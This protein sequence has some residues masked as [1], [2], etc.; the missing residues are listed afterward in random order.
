GRTASRAHEETVERGLRSPLRTPAKVRYREQD[1]PAEVVSETQQVAAGFLQRRGVIRLQ[2]AASRPPRLLV[3][4][5]GHPRQGLPQRL[6]RQRLERAVQVALEA[7]EMAAD[8]RRR[9]R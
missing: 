1:R 5:R 4:Q 7:Q 9:R 2:T 3:Q 6:F 8:A